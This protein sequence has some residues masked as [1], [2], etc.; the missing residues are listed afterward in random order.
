VTELGS[1]LRAWR[2]RIAPAT[3]GLPERGHRRT[4]GLRREELAALAG[5]SVDYLVRL[6]QGRAANP[7]PQIAASLARALRLTDSERDHLFRVAGHAPPGRH[8]V[9]THLTPGVQ[10]LLDRLDAAVSVHDASWT[11]VAWNPAWAALMGDP[12]ALGRRERNIVWRHFSGAP[13]RLVRTPEEVARFERVCVSDL[14]SA[15]G[16]Y[17][18]DEALSALIGEFRRTFE[19]FDALWSTAEVT[20]HHTDRKMVDHPEVGRLT[21]DCDVLTVAGSDLRVVAYTAVPGSVDQEKFDLVR[22]VGLQ[23]MV[24]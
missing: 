16:R 13:S 5:M 23:R 6:E 17:P 4:T 18:R 3:V 21:V 22:V 9:P 20:Y 19:R 7:S 14:R 12:S 15:L 11:V 8:Q 1:C 24:P 2:E 10:R